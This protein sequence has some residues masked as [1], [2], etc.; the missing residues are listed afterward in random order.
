MNTCSSAQGIHKEKYQDPGKKKAN[1][2]PM[3]KME[4]HADIISQ[5]YK[6]LPLKTET[7]VLKKNFFKGQNLGIYSS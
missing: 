1:I 7:L 6:T 3:R 2:V 4:L 5:T